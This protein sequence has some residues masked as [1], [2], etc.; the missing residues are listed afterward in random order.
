MFA[1]SQLQPPSNDPSHTA[2]TKKAFFEKKPARNLF[3]AAV[4]C[5]ADYFTSSRLMWYVSI[6]TQRRKHLKN[7]K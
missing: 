6:F 3:K 1:P 5:F 2:H 7:G 4:G